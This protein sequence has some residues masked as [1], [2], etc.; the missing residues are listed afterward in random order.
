MNTTN[1]TTRKNIWF[2]A[3]SH[4]GH[5]NIIRFCDR[6]FADIQEHDEALIANWN[7]SVQPGDDV[8]HL[9]DFCFR[10][11]PNK[12]FDRLNGNKHLCLGNH[13]KEKRLKRLPWAWIKGVYE[14]KI[15]KK[16]R[17][18]LSHYAHRRWPRSHHGSIH[19]F[20]HSHGGLPDF[21]KSTDVGVDAWDY[22]PV[23]LDT[24]LTYMRGKEK[25]E[26]HAPRV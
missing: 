2:T 18:W 14:L 5:A 3:D 17:V 12:V 19:L 4:F 11:D 26:H 20:G 25:T 22:K 23:H 15:D 10:G 24:I 8:Y 7:D 13:D 9:G 16:T 21:G 6:P 1:E